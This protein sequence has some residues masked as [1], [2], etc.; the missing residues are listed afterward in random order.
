MKRVLSLFV[1]L[2]LA[3]NFVFAQQ[4]QLKDEQPDEIKRLNEFS[5]RLSYSP[6]DSVLKRLEKMRARAI[7]FPEGKAVE[8]GMLLDIMSQTT[9]N[10][11]NYRDALLFDVQGKN[12]KTFNVKK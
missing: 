10:L 11:G 9:V 3:A 8:H 12:L 7:E 6:Q 1:L 2:S 5:R 4:I